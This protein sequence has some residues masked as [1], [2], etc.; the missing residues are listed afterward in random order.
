VSDEAGLFEVMYSCRAMRRIKPD[1]VP[2]ALLVKLIDAADQAPSGSNQ[3]RARWIVVR[4]A[5]VRARLAALN[6][7]AV[8]DYIS[9][10]GQRPQSV[11]HQDDAK[12]ERMLAALRWQAEHMQQIP[13]LVVA[14]MLFAG[15][16]DDAER[17]RGAGSIWPGVQNLLLAARALGLG[18]TPTTL[19]LRESAA[20]RD[21]LHM[22]AELEP[23]CL[24][25]L[26]WPL[27]RFG[28]VTRLP[29]EHTLRW[30]RW[31]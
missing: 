31:D 24:I 21:A 22:P 8:A 6:K 4:D 9:P 3:Q 5:A 27:G 11:A 12:R 26:G 23:Y 20:F 28:P 30:D 25:P 19:A 18:A 7:A 10:G 16:P 1:P 17:L 2:E 15:P 13:V 14:C 29:V